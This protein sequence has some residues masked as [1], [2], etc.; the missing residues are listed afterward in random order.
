[1][2][3]AT[4]VRNITA[5]RTVDVLKKPSTTLVLPEPAVLRQ[6]ARDLA[7]GCVLSIIDARRTPT[8]TE[9]LARKLPL[10]LSPRQGAPEIEDCL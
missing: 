5:P 1:M 4:N 8:H 2:S 9:D 6:D 3:P 10:S 7:T